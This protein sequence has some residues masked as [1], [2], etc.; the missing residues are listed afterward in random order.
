MY[1]SIKTS[2]SIVLLA[3]VALFLVNYSSQYDLEQN[4]IREENNLKPVLTSN[5]QL[6]P[7]KNNNNLISKLTSQ[8]TQKDASSVSNNKMNTNKE[9]VFGDDDDDDEDDKLDLE[10]PSSDTNMLNSNPFEMSDMSNKDENEDEEAESASQEDESEEEQNLLK[11]NQRVDVKHPSH[12]KHLPSLVKFNKM[13]DLQKKLLEL[14][15][16]K[17]NFDYDILIDDDFFEA[18]KKKLL[19]ATENKKASSLDPFDDDDDDDE[20]LEDDDEQGTITVEDLLRQLDSKLKGSEKAK[21]AKPTLQIK[22]QIYLE[23]VYNNNNN[24]NN[25][26]SDKQPEQNSFFN[27]ENEM[28]LE[29]TFTDQEVNDG[30]KQENTNRTGSQNIISN[31]SYKMRTEN[32]AHETVDSKYEMIKRQNDYLFLFVVAGCTLAGVLALLAA[33]VC[34]Y[35]VAKTRRVSKGSNE[36]ETSKHSIF[37]NQHTGS[38]SASGSIKSKGSA[39][40]GDKKLALS[41]QMYHFQHQKE[42]IIAMEKANSEAK[43]DDSDNS[44]DETPEGDYTVYECPGLAPTGEMEVKNPLFK[45][46]FSASSGSLAKSQAPPPSYSTVALNT[47]EVNETAQQAKPTDTPEQS[48]L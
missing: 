19:K 8:K 37:G 14:S 24:N 3:I 45:E 25:K 11:R 7:G 46:D 6:V 39:T 48:K 20:S 2:K 17:H 27:K 21:F 13:A 35:T 9:F 36:F 22:E 18:N 44:D 30:L 28:E 29:R 15:D 32:A 1:L 26:A 33:S 34:W 5:D 42:Q 43:P 12:E 16:N 40:S 4:I 10:I 41:A 31:P 23:G 47:S 38:S